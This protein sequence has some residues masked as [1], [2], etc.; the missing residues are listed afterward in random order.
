MLRGWRHIGRGIRLAIEC[1]EA[2]SAFVIDM[3]SQGVFDVTFWVIVDA[4]GSLICKLHT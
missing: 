2:E 3:K 4:Y 1:R